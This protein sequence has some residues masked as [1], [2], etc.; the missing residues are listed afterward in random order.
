MIFH[1]P[2]FKNGFFS[3]LGGGRGR[4][5]AGAYTAVKIGTRTTRIDAKFR[6]LRIRFFC[7]VRAIRVPFDV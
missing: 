3:P 6:M 1:A 5:D 2:I 4:V 7:V